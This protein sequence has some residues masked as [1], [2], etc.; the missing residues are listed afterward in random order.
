[1]NYKI[2]YEKVINYLAEEHGCAECPPE[3]IEQDKKCMACHKA[4]ADTFEKKK[5]CWRKNFEKV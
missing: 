5:M 4:N 1:M 2:L 3:D